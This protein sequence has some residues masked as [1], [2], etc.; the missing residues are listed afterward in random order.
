MKIATFISALYKLNININNNIIIIIFIIIIM[1]ITRRKKAKYLECCRRQILKSPLLFAGLC[2]ASFL[3]YL[4]N[5]FLQ[6][7]RVLYGAA[8]LYGVSMGLTVS[9]DTSRKVNRKA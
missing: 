4:S 9:G 7:C 6:L 3:S 1:S 8:I 2:G 5:H